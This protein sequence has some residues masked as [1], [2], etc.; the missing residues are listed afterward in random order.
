MHGVTTK[1]GNTFRLYTTI[2]LYNYIYLY[3]HPDHIMATCFD[4]KTVIIRPIENISKV[5]KLALNWI[6]FRLH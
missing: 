1:I 3:T 6:P 2:Y 5:K 4:R